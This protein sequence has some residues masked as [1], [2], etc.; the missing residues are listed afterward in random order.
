[1]KNIFIP[2]LV[3]SISLLSCVTE[4]SYDFERPIVNLNK[5]GVA[6]YDELSVIFPDDLSQAVVTT[7]LLCLSERQSAFYLL[8]DV[9]DDL[10]QANL[11]L[12]IED[13]L[14]LEGFQFSKVIEVPVEFNTGIHARTE[15]IDGRKNPYVV[16]RAPF[17]V[18]EVDKPIE[19]ADSFGF[20]LQQTGRALYVIQFENPKY[21]TYNEST[22]TINISIGEESY[23]KTIRLMQYPI[24]LDTTKEMKYIVWNKFDYWTEELGIE[25]Y[26]QEWYGKVA[27]MASLMKEGGQNIF[28]LPWSLL[29]EENSAD[30][31]N[32]VLMEERTSDYIRIFKEAG[33]ELISSSTFSGRKDGNWMAKELRLAAGMMAASPEAKVYIK[34]ACLQLDNYIKKMG[35]EDKWYFSIS[36]EP[37]FPHV[38]DYQLLAS[39]VHEF[40]PDIPILEATKAR[41]SLVGSIDVWCP[42]VDQYEMNRDFFVARQKAGEEVWVYTCLDPG[43]P[44][45]NRMLDQE[46][47]RQVWFGWTASLMDVTGYLHWGFNYYQNGVDPWK[48]SVVPFFHAGGPKAARNQLPAGDS[49]IAFPYEGEFVGGARLRAMA[50]G[51]QDYILLQ[52]LREKDE[53]KADFI[54]NRVVRGYKDYSKSINEYRDAKKALLDALLLD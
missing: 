35:L 18:Y 49:H 5:N 45:L 23:T 24:S 9:K 29:F 19:E 8:I 11:S 47:L 12:S 32:P 50:I 51:M 26:T 31:T 48:Q 52:M 4:I 54:I 16:R 15:L 28:S 42:T 44:W 10:G 30:P 22:L 33:I 21:A 53:A 13:Q 41:E 7:E 3:I 20:K 2:L 1:M 38:K 43:G 6:L 40:L 34:N 36:D 37:D 46:K 25:K 39:Y 17:D 14:G 27:Q